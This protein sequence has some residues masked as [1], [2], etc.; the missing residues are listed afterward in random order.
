MSILNV[1]LAQISHNAKT[2]IDIHLVALGLTCAFAAQFLTGQRLQVI[3]FN[4]I[5]FSLPKRRTQLNLW[6]LH[7]Y[8]CDWQH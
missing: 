1:T 7:N 6:R 2:L 8:C 4:R 3:K 5:T